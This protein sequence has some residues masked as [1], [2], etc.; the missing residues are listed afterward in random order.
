MVLYFLQF[1]PQRR[2]TIIFLCFSFR[3]KLTL[4]SDLLEDYLL[5][6][7]ISDSEVNGAL[8]ISLKNQIV[9]LG[10]YKL[11]CLAFEFSLR[12]AFS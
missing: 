3:N 2:L 9:D 1:L 10:L 7:A 12:T 11:C 6:V 8:I 4:R 5:S